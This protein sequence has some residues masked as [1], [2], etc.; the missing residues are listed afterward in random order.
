MLKAQFATPST[1]D[2]AIAALAG[3]EGARAIAGGTDL[4]VQ[5]RKGGAHP[6]PLLVSLHDLYELKSFVREGEELRVGSCVTLLD[7]LESELVAELAP[8]LAE[9]AAEMASP[10]VRSRAPVGGNLCNASPAADLAPPLLLHDARVALQGPEGERTVALSE[11]LTGPGETL[12]KAEELLTGVILTPLPE[13][14]GAAYTKYQAS[15]CADLSIVSVAAA[16]RLGDGGTCEEARVALGAVAPTAVRVPE[17]EDLLV[18]K[19]LDDETLAAAGARASDLCC[20]ID[21]IRSTCDNRCHLVGVLLPRTLGEAA[22]RAAGQ[23][24]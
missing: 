9:V 3:T 8:L 16:I 18:G 14:M 12:R 21:D 15:K 11:F 4:M 6:P 2:E 24:A 22:R 7:L 13:G 20:P 23:E 10:H 19:P 1:V 5:L 17:V